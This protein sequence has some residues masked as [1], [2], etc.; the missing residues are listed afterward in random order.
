MNAQK[1]PNFLAIV[2]DV[3]QENQHQN[4]T[5]EGAQI[6]MSLRIETEKV[7]LRFF[8]FRHHP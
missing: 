4:S 8:A 5:A 7:S 3:P 1:R 6:I 2:I